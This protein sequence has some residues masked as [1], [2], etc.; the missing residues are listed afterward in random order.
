MGKILSFKKW[1]ED[2]GQVFTFLNGDGNYSV[3][4][5]KYQA[6]GEKMPKKKRGKNEKFLGNLGKHP[7]C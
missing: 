1:L 3:I 2:T 5:S 6:Q 7:L 4:P